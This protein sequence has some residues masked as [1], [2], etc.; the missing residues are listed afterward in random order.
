MSASVG[1]VFLLEGI[2]AFPF[3]RVKPCSGVRTDVVWHCD[4]TLLVGGFVLRTLRYFVCGVLLG[5]R[6]CSYEL[7]N[8]DLCPSVVLSQV[9]VC[10]SCGFCS[11]CPFKLCLCEVFGPGFS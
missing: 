10:S 8:D 1:A 6:S 3:L 5:S 9:F 11:V 7:G 4:A 2:L